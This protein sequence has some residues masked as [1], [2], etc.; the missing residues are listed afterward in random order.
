MAAR[1][2]SLPQDEKALH[3]RP[4]IVS[5]KQEIKNR[6]DHYLPKGYLKGFIDVS[7][8]N[9]ERPLWRFDVRHNSW[10]QRSTTGV[11]YRTGF[12]DY[13]GTGWESVE[14]AFLKLENDYPLICARIVSS[15]FTEWI[16]HRMFLLSYMQMMSARSLLFFERMHAKGK[17][18]K[19]PVVN[20]VLPDGKV[21][22]SFA[23]SLPS[24]GLIKNWSLSQMCREMM[25]G[26][27]ELYDFDWTL[28]FCDSPRD[29]FVVSESPFAL[30]GSR[31]E[32][33][34]EEAFQHPDSLLFFPLC[35]QAILV[36]SRRPFNIKTD[37]FAPADIR[38]CRRMYRD[39]AK[40]FLVSPSKLNDF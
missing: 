25:R 3:N 12:Y 14:S 5:N 39:S 23:P 24:E 38:R 32:A 22:L 2:A 29:P 35:W 34:L 18:L 21:N 30:Q 20:E 8:E 19:V 15:G 9:E 36:G 40:L 10:S 4:T 13:A 7:C 16:G 26:A 27:P 1:E 11:G 17:D 37:R 33:T 31:P 28:R 6:R